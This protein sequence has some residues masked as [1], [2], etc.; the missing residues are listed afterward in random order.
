MSTNLFSIEEISK[1]SSRSDC[2]I[3][4][5]DQ[6]WDVTEFAPSHPGGPGVIHRYAGRDATQA[7]SEIHAPSIIKDHLSA[8]NLKGRIDPSTVSEEWLKPLPTTPQATPPAD[9][10]RPELDSIINANDF[11]VAAQKTSSAKTWAFYSSAADD[12]ITRDANRSLYSRIW[13]RPRIM[14]DVRAVS[15]SSTILGCATTLPIIISPAAMAKLIHPDGEL[16]IARAAQSRGIIQCISTSAS[17]PASEIVTSTADRNHPFFFQLYVD[18]QRHKSE[19]LLRQLHQHKNVKAIFVTVDAAAAG[20]REA[21]ERVKADESLRSPMTGVA[22]PKNDSR[23]GGYGRI[24]GSFID[25]G[26]N[27]SDVAWLRSQTRLPLVLKGV[28][29]ASDVRLALDHGLDGVMLSNHGGRNL[30]TSPPAILTLLEC[31]RRC[32]HV[33]GRLDIFVDG[34]IRRGTDVLKSLALGATAVGL[35][36][37]V[38]FATAYGQEGVEHLLD[39]MRDELEV[40]MRNCGVARL[41]DV[42]PEM[43]NTG[44][45][46]H[47]VPGTEGHPYMRNWRRRS[48]KARL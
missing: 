40:A 30:D 34:G 6:V 35:G 20:K 38:L 13:F 12:L 7:Y 2:W 48:L 42:G 36:R 28:T 47:L 11:E 8:S 31:H 1:H 3:V 17:Y 9:S 27:W 18:K 21:D 16:A 33:F 10:E 23:G 45:L 41:E 5:D 43:V 24:M 19:T 25:P 22:A 39:I 14:R 46:D 29:S 4:I 26:L 37:P 32:P 15:T 44:D